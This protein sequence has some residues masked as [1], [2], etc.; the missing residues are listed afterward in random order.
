MVAPV[1][2]MLSGWNSAAS[3]DL[4]TSAAFT[5]AHTQTHAHTHTDARAHTAL[6]ANL[7]FPGSF[8]GLLVL[9]KLN[10]G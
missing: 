6:T 10:G 7:I 9:G 2:F 5:R 8:W 4:H 1:I 3:L